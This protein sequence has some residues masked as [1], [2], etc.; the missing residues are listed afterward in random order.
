[1]MY[2]HKLFLYTFK[3]FILFLTFN[4]VYIK[5]G[6]GNL[7]CGP[8][9]VPYGIAID[10]NGTPKIFCQSSPCIFSDKSTNTKFINGYDNDEYAHCSNELID[11][12]CSG[13]TEWTAGLFEIN[14]STHILL[15]TKCCDFH[16]MSSAIEYKSSIL[17]NN[18]HYIG[19]KTNNFS[20]IPSYDLIKEVVKRV[21][22]QN[23]FYY[24][25][26][27]YRIQCLTN[28]PSFYRNDI[29]TANSIQLSNNYVDNN[30]PQ[31]IPYQFNGDQKKNY[32][33]IKEHDYPYQEQK[34]FYKKPTQ[35]GSLNVKDHSL[36]VMREEESLD[37]MGNNNKLIPQIPNQI[38]FI[39]SITPKTDIGRPKASGG[40]LY[41][42]VSSSGCDN[43]CGSSFI[44]Q[45]V[46]SCGTCG[47]SA[48][49]SDYNSIFS[50]L[51]CFSG[52]MKVIIPNGIKKMK[53]VKIGDI[54]LSM[55][56]SS[57]TFNKVIGFLH[58][59]PNLTATFNHLITESKKE[60]K[61]TDYHLIYKS[62]CNIKDSKIVL[63]YAKDIKIGDCVYTLIDGHQ[64]NKF[65]KEKVKEIK[66]VEEIGIYSPLTTSGDIIVNNFLASCHN[67]FAAQ[68]LQQTFFKSWQSVANVVWRIKE[69]LYS[70]NNFIINNH[71]SIEEEFDIPFGVKYIIN[72]IDMIVPVK[73]FI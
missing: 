70:S 34:S 54:V 32:N 2:I 26:S 6:S 29:E 56:E 48:P 50:S 12:S 33:Y 17:M 49:A 39:T 38:P 20:E 42:P 68:S 4:I 24:I 23:E 55:E 40:I 41:H 53:D 28:S 61:L 47:A 7:S 72:V 21:T 13:E 67:N 31:Y 10:S 18:D 15:K 64:N 59:K 9:E 46:Y 11:S 30:I 62:Q 52:D 44:Q 37:Y 66:K 60:L 1:M 5:C 57:V 71:Y 22:E 19:G 16:R 58:R 27:I 14:N 25:V 36:Q 45:P 73:M 35:G 43:G 51:H 63:S 69:L 65:L 3:V 8:K